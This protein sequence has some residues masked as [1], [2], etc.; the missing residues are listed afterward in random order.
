M[1]SAPSTGSSEALVEAGATELG[2]VEAGV[3]EA[4][5][6]VVVVSGRLEPPPHAMARQAKAVIRAAAVPERGQGG[7]FTTLPARRPARRRAGG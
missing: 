6:R 4:G 5:G 3:V 7:R 1:M 2:A